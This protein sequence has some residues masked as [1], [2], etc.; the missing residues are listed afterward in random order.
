MPV[1]KQAFFIK[2]SRGKM[3]ALVTGASSGIG[4]EMAIYLASKKIDLILAARRKENLEILKKELETTYGIHVEVY[5]CDL[6]DLKACYQLFEQFPKIDIL[7]NNAGFGDAG[8]FIKTDLDKEL[9]MIDLNIKAMH[10]LCKKYAQIFVEQK[11]GYILNVASLAAF[12]AGPK[13]A[14]YYATK[15]YVLHL[16]EALN[17]ELKKAKHPV[18]VTALCPGPVETEFNQVANVKFHM[19]EL[20]AKKVAQIGI[21]AMFKKKTIVIP[22]LKGKLGVF[23]ERFISR[24]LS[25][26]I[27][28]RVQEKK[29]NGK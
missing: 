14:T 29:Q 2:E 25:N 22:G 27:I 24:K 20:S 17:Y 15:A 10:I 7:I 8:E 16:S 19:K 13:M 1:V 23:F 28:C 5:P 11:S 12:Q 9:A 21:D 18:S 26:K 3:R 4:K 6:I